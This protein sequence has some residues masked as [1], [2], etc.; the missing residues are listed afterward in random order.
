MYIHAV[1]AIC[2]CM[3][4]NNHLYRA[5]LNTGEKEKKKKTYMYM[6]HTSIPQ[7]IHCI[8]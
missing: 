6:K 1:D 7:P 5:P 3:C 2:T 8:L 4:I